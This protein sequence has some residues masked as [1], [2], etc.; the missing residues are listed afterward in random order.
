MNVSKPRPSD[1]PLLIVFVIGGVTPTEV[2]QIK[3]AVAAS[4]TSTQVS[5]LLLD[6]EIS[7][8]VISCFSNLSLKG[9]NALFFL[10]RYP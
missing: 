5:S 2:K 6:S 10:E 8:F 1:H 7:L 9:S 4:K 3:D